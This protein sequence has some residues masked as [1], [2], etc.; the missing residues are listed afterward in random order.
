MYSS[1][2]SSRCFYSHL[3]RFLSLLSLLSI[4]QAF[5]CPISQTTHHWA[6]NRRTLQQDR[7][8]NKISYFERNSFHVSSSL[9]SSSSSPESSKWTPQT[10]DCP[11]AGRTVQLTENEDDTE[12]VC[13]IRLN[14]DG[15][16]SMVGSYESTNAKEISGSWTS[17]GEDKIALLLNRHYVTDTTGHLKEERNYTMERIYE[18]KFHV[19][20]GLSSIRGE[21]KIE[22]EKYSDVFACGIFS[23]V[24]TD[25]DDDF[26]VKTNGAT[27]HTDPIGTE[28]D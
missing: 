11:L 4:G 23:F 10:Q 12:R 8:R 13:N 26:L 24:T 7:F 1:S 28:Y 5:L 16:V 21:G 27:H 9:R 17:R 2:S 20:K 6:R 19:T 14:I 3:L 18:G 25:D 22:Q 15:T